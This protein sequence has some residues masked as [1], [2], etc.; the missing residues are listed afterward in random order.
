MA[1]ALPWT[2]TGNVYVSGESDAT[3][4]SPIRGFTTGID[5]FVANFDNNENLLWNTFL[6]G[7]GNDYGWGIV[8]NEIGNVY[9][10]GESDAHLG[11]FDPPFYQ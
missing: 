11:N 9:V 10:T 1:V 6:G 5:A 7:G 3:W 4:G 2:G 8:A